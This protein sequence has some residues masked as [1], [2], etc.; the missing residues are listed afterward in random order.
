MQNINRLPAHLLIKTVISARHLQAYD[1]YI[2]NNRYFVPIDIDLNDMV[3]RVE[4]LL[5]ICPRGLDPR[6]DRLIRPHSVTPIPVMFNHYCR[7]I[8]PD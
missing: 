7:T 5:H 6:L 4:G 1:Y 2:Y 8:Y 3:E